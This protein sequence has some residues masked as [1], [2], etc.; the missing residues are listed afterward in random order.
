V[1]P[2]KATT[3][4][5]KKSKISYQYYHLPNYTHTPEGHFE[6]LTEQMTTQMATMEVEETGMPGGMKS[7]ENKGKA[8]EPPREPSPK[9]RYKPGFFSQDFG[10]RGGGGDGGRPNP[11]TGTAPAVYPQAPSKKRHI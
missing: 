3:A 1:H 8:K 2:A 6:S 9:E 11:G 7:S 5:L 10:E 4:A